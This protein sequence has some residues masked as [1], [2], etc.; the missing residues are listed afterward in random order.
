MIHSE[1]ITALTIAII[2]AIRYVFGSGSEIKHLKNKVAK[3][4][5]SVDKC[6]CR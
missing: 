6:W 3:L 1:D 2:G 4:G 5:C